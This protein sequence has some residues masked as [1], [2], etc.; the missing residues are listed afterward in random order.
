MHRNSCTTVLVSDVKKRG[1]FQ[2]NGPKIDILTS[3]VADQI[4]HVKEELDSLQVALLPRCCCCL[5]S[6]TTL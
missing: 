3:K 5:L 2:N 4:A 1:L 6:P